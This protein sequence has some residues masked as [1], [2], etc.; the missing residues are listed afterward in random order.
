MAYGCLYSS[1]KHNGEGDDHYYIGKIT[2]AG[3][4]VDSKARD[5][6][7]KLQP[8]AKLHFTMVH[9]VEENMYNYLTAL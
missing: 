3:S 7:G 2:P 8:V 1:K 4:A 6:K 5:K 9:P